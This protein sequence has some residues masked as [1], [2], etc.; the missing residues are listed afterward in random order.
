MPEFED[1]FIREIIVRSYRVVYRLDNVRHLVEVIRF[2]HAA[3]GTP[4]INP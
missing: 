2:W 3:R 1:P 4:E